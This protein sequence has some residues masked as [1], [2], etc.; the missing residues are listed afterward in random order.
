M[1]LPH[2]KAE[3]C[4][5]HGI[6]L[7]LRSFDCECDYG[8]VEDDEGGVT[9]WVT[10]HRCKGAGEIECMTCELCEEEYYD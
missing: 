2:L 9:E 1:I 6:P 7:H 5:K 4:K 8:E 10:C 3:T